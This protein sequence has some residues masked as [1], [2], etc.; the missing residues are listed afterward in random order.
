MA[1]D[2]P[3]P[4][5]PLRRPADPADRRLLVAAALV[6]GCGQPAVKQPRFDDRPACAGSYGV[7]EDAGT[8]GA[9]LVEVSGI[10][11]S[12]T[13][14]GL[15]W[16]IVDGGQQPL[17][18]AVRADGSVLGRVTINGAT[19]FDVE[20]V[21]AAHCPDGDGFCLFLSDTGDNAHARTDANVTIVREPA[22]ALDAG[23]DARAL[24]PV[25]R[26]AIHFPAGEPIDVEALAVTAD[27]RTL[28]LFEKID[29]PRARVFRLAAPFI[30]DVALMTTLDSPGVGV[31]WGKAIT[32]ADL[33]PSGT[34]L[35]LRVYTGVFEYRFTD[36]GALGATPP[37]T[38]LFGPLTEPQGEAIAYDGAG[39]GLWLASEDP[40]GATPQILHHL[41]CG[42]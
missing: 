34:R 20:D 2:E 4:G 41:P 3:A 29:G 33:H 24:A 9:G 42:K 32:G 10:A 36:V 1:D 19:F 5:Q 37:T 31:R 23:F 15:S 35:A 38:V 14:P 28:L 22:V 8:L 17:L 7:L 25:S 27:G 6:L 26:V 12:P 18:F 40:Q 11:A 16:M 39:T 21:A 13:T 30:G